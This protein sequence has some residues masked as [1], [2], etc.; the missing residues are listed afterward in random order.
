[1]SK[2]VGQV[3]KYDGCNFFRQRIILSIISG[4][5]IK[6]RK[7]R[8]MQQSPGIQGKGIPS[9]ILY[10]TLV[11]QT[12]FWVYEIRSQDVATFL[13]ERTFDEVTESRPATLNVDLPLTM[14]M[15]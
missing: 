5:S 6:I 14:H 12:L 11:F 1:M 4:K 9:D 15:Q 10:I 2:T 13:M 8:L 7:I 3:L